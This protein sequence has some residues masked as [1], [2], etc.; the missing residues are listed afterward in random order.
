MNSEGRRGGSWPI[1]FLSRQM[2]EQTE[3]ND[4]KFHHSGV[5]RMLFSYSKRD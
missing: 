3:K 4:G 1:Q 5:Q 2:A